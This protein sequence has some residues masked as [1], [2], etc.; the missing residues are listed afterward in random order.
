MQQL[1][2]WLELELESRQDPVVKLVYYG[3]VSANTLEGVTFVSP[4]GALVQMFEPFRLIDAKRL[5]HSLYKAETTQYHLR[6]ASILGISMNE[7]P[8]LVRYI[9]QMNADTRQII[10]ALRTLK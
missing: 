3:G 1:A 7:V 5:T 10:K 2:R 6:I 8:Q 9:Y 4:L